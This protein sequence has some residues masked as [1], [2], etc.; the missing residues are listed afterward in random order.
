MRL[1][2][3]QIASSIAAL[4]IAMAT[5]RYMSL[6]A[7]AMGELPLIARAAILS[8]AVTAAL[9]AIYPLS[10]LFSSQPGTYG[11]FVYLPALVPGFVY[12]LILL[13]NQAGVGVTAQQVQSQLITDRSSNGIIEV[14]FSYPIYTPTLTLTNHELFTRQVNVFLRMVDANDETAL[15]RAVRQ[16]IPGFGLSV[17]AT[18]QGMLSQNAEYLYLPLDLPPGRSITGRLVF[19]ISNLDDGSSFSEALAESNQ[20]QIELRDPATGELV[21][22]FSLERT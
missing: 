7:A 17:E 9:V 4:L 2:L 11:L 10:S 16:F 20:T 21:Y 14:G 22:Q 5:I 19:I 12:Y 13:P 6:N 15:F 1:T 3:L 8:L 18:V